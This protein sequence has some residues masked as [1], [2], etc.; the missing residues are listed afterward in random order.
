MGVK[1]V[2]FKKIKR[3]SL[4]SLKKYDYLCNIINKYNNLK[5]KEYERKYN[6][7]FGK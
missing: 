3:K 7:V 1:N 4:A 2:N 5:Q 6:R